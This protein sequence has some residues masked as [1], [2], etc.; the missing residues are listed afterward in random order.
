MSKIGAGLIV[1]GLVIFYLIFF[2]LAPFVCDSIPAGVYKQLLSI[3]AYI[4]LGW[5][6]GVAI[7]LVIILIGI[8]LIVEDA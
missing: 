6:G 4:V 5:F 7:P 1:V 8:E 2:L 3:T